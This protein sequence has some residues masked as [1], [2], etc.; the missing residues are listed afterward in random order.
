[1]AGRP[2]GAV[3]GETGGS[4]WRRGRSEWASSGLAPRR[5]CVICSSVGGEL[6]RLG[7]TLACESVETAGREREEAAAVGA[8]NDGA[9]SD[10]GETASVG[11]K[12]PAL[13]GGRPSDDESGSE[14]SSESE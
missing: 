9:K 3:D 12:V 1:M 10:L 7:P 14:S 5:R 6:V 2:T 4:E 8:A 13:S 11:T